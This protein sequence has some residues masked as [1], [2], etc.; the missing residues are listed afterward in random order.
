MAE[1]FQALGLS[2]YAERG[3]VTNEYLRLFKELWTAEHPQF[4]GKY[5][6][7]AGVGF[8]PKPVQKPHPP[9]WIGGHSTPALRRAATLGDGWMPI[10]LRPQSLLEPADMEGKIARLRTLTSQAG[11]PKEAV[12]ISFTAPIVFTRASASDRLLLQG[13]PDAIAADLRQYR[14]LG[15][16]NFNINLPAG[17]ISQQ[18]EVMEQF[19]REVVPQIPQE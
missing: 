6:Q 9:I 3:A 17:S 13:H 7:V 1:E 5:C 15:V 11:R 10:G 2:T 12:T 16:Q 8:Q 19:V 14:A 18:Q 4:Q